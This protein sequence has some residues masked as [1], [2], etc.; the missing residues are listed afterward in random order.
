MLSSTQGW[1]FAIWKILTFFIHVILQNWYSSSTLS[2]KIDILKNNQ[3]NKC[4]CIHEII[5]LNITKMKMKNGSHRYDIN[6]PRHGHKYSV[7]VWW[8]LY[9]LSNI[10]SSIQEKVKQQKSA[11][12]K[13]ACIISNLTFSI[14]KFY[15]IFFLFVIVFSINFIFL[16]CKF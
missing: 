5:R 10:W 1:T 13:K 6:R 7:S 12:C 11:A 2:S 4:F 3:K 8:C 9:V 15:L 14:F 16:I